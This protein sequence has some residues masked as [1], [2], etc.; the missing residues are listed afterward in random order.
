M[1][2]FVEYMMT[3]YYLDCKKLLVEL[4]DSQVDTLLSSIETRYKFLVDIRQDALRDKAEE[5]FSAYEQA[6]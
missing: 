6:V 5:R 1:T 3:S 4:P 2:L